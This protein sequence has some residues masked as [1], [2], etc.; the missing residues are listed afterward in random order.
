[1]IRTSPRSL[2]IAIVVL[3]WQTTFAQT[4]DTRVAVTARGNPNVR[5]IT[6]ETLPYQNLTTRIFKVYFV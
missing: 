5:L 6:L 4:T 3:A 1:M 2:I